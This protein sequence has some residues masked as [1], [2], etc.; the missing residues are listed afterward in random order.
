M[1][2]RIG[3]ARGLLS[4]SGVCDTWDQAN[5]PLTLSS[6]CCLGTVCVIATIVDGAHSDTTEV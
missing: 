2:H 5:Y 3:A 1:F 4:Q 6:V